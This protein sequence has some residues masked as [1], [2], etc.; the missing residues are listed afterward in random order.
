[1]KKLELKQMEKLQGG[2]T[3]AEYCSKIRSTYENCPDERNTDGM[4][5]AMSLCSSIDPR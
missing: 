2:D 4:R 5:F 1:M 3:A